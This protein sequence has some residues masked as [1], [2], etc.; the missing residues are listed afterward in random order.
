MVLNVVL[1]VDLMRVQGYSSETVDARDERLA[2]E[3]TA[4][5][6]R[7]SRYCMVVLHLVCVVFPGTNSRWYGMLLCPHIF[8]YSTMLMLMLD[9]PSPS[10][11]TQGEEKRS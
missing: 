10:G 3:E 2:E 1:Y 9:A 4:K 6:N 8:P 7:D 5:E 11:V